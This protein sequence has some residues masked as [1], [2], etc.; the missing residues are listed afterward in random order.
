MMLYQLLA[1]TASAFSD[2]LAIVEEKRTF[3]YLELL[4]AVERL[5]RRLREQGLTPGQTIAVQIPN[6][7]ECVTALF[8]AAA[9]NGT[10]LLLDPALKPEEVERYCKRA[11]ARTLLCGSPATVEAQED[12]LRRCL[13]PAM[14]ALCEGARRR[15]RPSEMGTS[16]AEAGRTLFLLLSSGTMGRP[17]IISRTVA[18][19]EAALTIFRD[20]IPYGEEDRVL[21]ILPFFHSFGLLN[22]FLGTF[23]GGATL[24]LESF[25]PRK[26][27]ATVERERITAL[28]A[29]P[30]M[31]RMLA[32]TEFRS[33]PDFSSCRLAVSAGS[34][35]SFGVSRKFREK[36]GI[37]IAESYGTTETGPVA[38]ARPGEPMDESPGWVGGPY[39]GVTIET[40]GPS[41]EPVGPGSE[42]EVAVKSAANATGYLDDPE[43]NAATFKS[44]YVLTGD[45]GHLDEAGHLFVLGRRKP[46][47]NIA[48]K[49]VSPA[50]VE[51]CLRSHPRVADVLV[52]GAKTADGGERVQALVVPAGEVTALELQA[53]CGTRLADF[54]VPRTV[55]FVENL[56]T[57]AMG[58][59]PGTSVSQIGE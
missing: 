47:L 30:F 53:F 40:W 54:K 27:A 43:A 17:K 4:N 50:E 8:A 41:G 20:T 18:Q 22:V 33:A 55:T 35:L 5:Q 11:G 15:G 29:T 45:I 32:E 7:A 13:V 42:G 3:S 12:G 49:K 14:D 9:L 38:L 31:F 46:M 21:G 44:G 52:T 26:T 19:A 10:I 28:P 57:G 48:G 36:F 34:A 51:A 2:R 39:V 6:S 23:A 59:A 58:K 25:S 1:R 24:Y 37:A 16:R 56:S